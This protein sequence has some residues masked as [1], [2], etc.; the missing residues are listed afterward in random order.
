MSALLIVIPWSLFWATAANILVLA[1]AP[2]TQRRLITTRSLRLR[3]HRLPTT[4][5]THL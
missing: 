3:E 2:S 4:V 5:Q 1:L